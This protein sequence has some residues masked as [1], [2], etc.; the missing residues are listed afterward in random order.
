MIIVATGIF[1]EQP[2]LPELQQLKF[3]S[4]KNH[5]TYKGLIGV[6]PS[7]AVFVSDPYSVSISDK[8]LTRLCAILDIL[9]SSNSVMAD[10]GF[11]IEEDLALLEV[12]VEHTPIL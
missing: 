12:K 11:D 10:R 9:E 6:S 3:S 1:I 7:G 2:S 5:Y 4:Y 8:Q